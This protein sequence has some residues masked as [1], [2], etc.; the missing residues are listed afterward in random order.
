MGE[1]EGPRMRDRE[2]SGARNQMKRRLER[3]RKKPPESAK[4]EIE[5]NVQ[6]QPFRGVIL[7]IKSCLEKIGFK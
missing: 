1:R 2:D 6:E 4:I 3:S 5:H 7:G